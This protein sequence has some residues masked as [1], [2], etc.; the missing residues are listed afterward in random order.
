VL[1][2][3]NAEPGRAWKV[4]ELSKLAGASRAAFVRL[5]HA[6]VG[7]SPQ[8]FLRAAR[9]E[10][11]AHLLRET[12]APLSEIAPLVGYQTEFALSRAFKRHYGIAPAHYRKAASPV[13]CTAAAA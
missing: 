7:T 12:S 11:A 8:R 1:H 5:F 6:A 2:A 13:L 9:L 4:S 10:H 3:V